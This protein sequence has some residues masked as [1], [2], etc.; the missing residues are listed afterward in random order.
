MA[1]EEEKTPVENYTE[2]VSLLLME[3]WDFTTGHLENLLNIGLL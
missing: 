2:V 1:S 3:I